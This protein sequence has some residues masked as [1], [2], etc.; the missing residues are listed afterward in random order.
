MKR[1]ARVFPTRTAMTPDDELAFVNQPPPLLAMPEVDEIHVSVTFSWDRKRAEVLAKEWEAV[2]VPVKIGGVAYGKPSGEFVPGLYVRK[3]A[4]ITSRGC[5]NRCWFCSVPKREGGLRELPVQDGWNVLDDNLLACSDEH[6]REVFAMLKRQ[7]RK[8]EFT[9]GL[10]SK[11]LKPWHAQA[12]ADLK[13]ARMYFA[14]DTPD[15]YEPLVEAGKMLRAAGISAESHKACCYCLIGYKGDTFDK[16]E[17]RL[18]DTIKAGFLPYAMLYRDETGAMDKD[19]RR[20]Q[21]EWLRAPIVG[22]K[23]REIWHGQEITPDKGDGV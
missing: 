4:T 9:G 1:I 19:W 11:V 2:G 3:G 6:V 12:L 20:F 22:T 8:A 16:A 15:D 21:R 14:Y 5:P 10:E 13:P 17:K 23:M 7:P 18:T